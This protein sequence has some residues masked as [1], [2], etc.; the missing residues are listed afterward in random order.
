M[1]E[2]KLTAATADPLHLYEQ[3][4]QD[5]EITINLIDRIYRGRNGRLAMSLR[6][7]FCG[8]AQL[9]ADW[10]LSDPRVFLVSASDVRL[11]PRILQAASQAGARPSD[12][13]M[14][15][16]VDAQEMELIFEGRQTVSGR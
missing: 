10:V 9:C 15:E 7:D 3:S 8:T 6:E 11:L 13:E 12:V 5:T 14:R 16:M 1:N 4:V 2:P